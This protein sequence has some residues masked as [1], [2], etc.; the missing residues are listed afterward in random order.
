[1]I[2]KQLK[3]YSLVELLKIVFYR[4]GYRFILV[5]EK[6][7]VSTIKSGE[8]K[9][10]QVPK[11]KFDNVQKIVKQFTL[12]PIK[13]KQNTIDDIEAG[14]IVLFLEKFD[15]DSWLKDPISG[16][17]WPANDYFVNARTKIDGYGDVKYV[18]E[19][20]KF[21]HLVTVAAAFYF[22]GN[23]KH[24]K[25]IEKQLESWVK[26]IRYGYS[27]VNRI[28]MDCAFRCINLIFISIFCNKSHYF[29]SNVYP[30]IHQILL[31]HERQMDK[32]NTPR[33]FKTGNGANHVIGEM[34]GL[35]VLKIWISLC[36]DLKKSTEK[37]YKWL[38]QT[39]DKL[40]S[41]EGVYLEYSSNYSR[42]VGEFLVVLDMFEPYTVKRHNTRDK[43]LKPMLAYITSL[44]HHSQL[45]NFG[46]NDAASILIPYKTSFDDIAPLYKYA[47]H[48][49]C[50]GNTPDKLSTFTK[51][52]QFVW[53]SF[54]ES[55]LYIFIRCGKWSIFRQGASVHS[56]NDIL[57]MILMYG[58]AQIF[59]DKGCYFYNQSIEMK[60]E[61]IRTSSHNTVYVSG[62]EQ[63][64]YINGGWYNYPTSN[65]INDNSSDYIF[66][67]E[68]YYKKIKHQRV[69]QYKENK[70]IIKDRITKTLRNVRSYY[71]YLL[72]ENISIRKENDNELNLFFQNR[73]LAKITIEGANVE[74]T[75]ENYYP[76]YANKVSTKAI[77]GSLFSD[78]VRTIIEFYK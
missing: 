43:Y 56:H 38:Y 26:E 16:K 46:D 50:I 69:I 4:I 25:Y 1:M 59:V 20:N 12:V 32:F 23:E 14:K 27:V 64:D 54:D 66:K 35:I 30:L 41:P 75:N 33:W 10:F 52:G 58:E 49:N 70:I 17:K 11:Y 28:I 34:V 31:L 57:S 6:V 78:T 62:Y 44:S 39:L 15:I 74:I 5:I 65:F 61:Y 19:L 3:Q 45:P 53:K 7:K 24:V 9:R 42:L 60:K 29:K 73:K 67:G 72:H 51:S 48:L 18:L 63:A 8:I 47:Q 13:V 77:M 2:I 22:D 55:D 36:T 76:H 40:M 37:E 71:H 21:N 68:V